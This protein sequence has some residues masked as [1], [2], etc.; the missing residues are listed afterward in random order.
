LN[1][2]DGFLYDLNPGNRI[3]LTASP[4]LP[5]YR[6]GANAVAI[7]TGNMQGLAM[8]AGE[9]LSLVNPAACQADR[10]DNYYFT[11]VTSFVNL[12]KLTA[13]TKWLLA[14]FHH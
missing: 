13:Q 1:T 11:A 10:S 12:P 3:S 9:N 4:L 7:Q 5:F 8:V 14:S 6:K 2:K